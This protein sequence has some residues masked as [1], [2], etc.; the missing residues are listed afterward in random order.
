METSCPI[1]N[2]GRWA[3]VFIMFT[4]VGVLGLLAGSLASFF[5]PEPSDSGASDSEA[6]EQDRPPGSLDAVM[7]ELTLLRAQVATLTDRLGGAAT[8]EVD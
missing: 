1:T 8:D 2:T 7:G 5:R 4:G 3:G 6:G